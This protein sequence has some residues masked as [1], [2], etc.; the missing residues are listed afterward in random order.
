M[1]NRECIEE[2]KRVMNSVTLP[3]ELGSNIIAK[4]GREV[5]A[6][7]TKYIRAVVAFSGIAA[8]AAGI[9]AIALLNKRF[10]D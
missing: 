7:G 4:S 3:E 8:V 10:G 1:T 2:Y 6:G 5:L 9:G